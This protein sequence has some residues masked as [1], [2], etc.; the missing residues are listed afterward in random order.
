M[1]SL[2]GG[3]RQNDNAQKLEQRRFQLQ[4][5]RQ[6]FIGLDNVAATIVSIGVNGPAPALARDRTEIAPGP[7]SSRELAADDLPVFHWRH[8]ARFS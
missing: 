3:E 4:E 6:E 1:S 7:T 2:I 5:R 8:D